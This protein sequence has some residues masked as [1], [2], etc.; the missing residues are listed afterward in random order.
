MY[1]GVAGQRCMPKMESNKTFEAGIIR[2]PKSHINMRIIQ[3]MISGIPLIL[4][5]GIRK[6]YPYVDV[7]VWAS[8]YGQLLEL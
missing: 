3:N 2:P 1:L 8:N 5:L 6:S 4:G 7:V